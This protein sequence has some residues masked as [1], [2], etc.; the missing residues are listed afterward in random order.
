MK[1]E[2]SVM[3]NI[4][5]KGFNEINIWTIETELYNRNRMIYIDDE[6]DESLSMAVIKQIKYLSLVSNEPI[7]LVIS[8]PGGDVDY[9]LAIIDEIMN[10]GCRVEAVA[11]GRVASMAALIFAMCSNRQM[12]KHSTILIHNPFLLSG[13]KGTVENV[14][15]QAE[16]LIDIQNLQAEMLSKAC[17]QTKD[18]MLEICNKDQFMSAEEALKLGLCDEIIGGKENA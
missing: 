6:I 7:K 14:K 15:Q 18:K 9:G 16:H 11:I 13:A 5:Q 1:K 3:P 10:C 17:K 8:S 12:Y 4:V 2:N